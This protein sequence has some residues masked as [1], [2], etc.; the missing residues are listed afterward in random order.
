LS[1]LVKQFD[2]VSR[3]VEVIDAGALSRIT[4][5]INYAEVAKA[6]GEETAPE[7]AGNLSLPFL[8]QLNITR[9]GT[10]TLA[11]IAIGILVPLYRFSERLAAFY[12]SRAD[13]LRL[14]QTVGYKALVL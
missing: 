6:I 14:H 1:S 5:E 7:A 12:R 3:N 9:F 10:I 2:S 13:A 11:S 8:L 4:S